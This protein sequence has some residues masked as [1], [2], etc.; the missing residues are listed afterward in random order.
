MRTHIS[1]KPNPHLLLI[2]RKG[3][4]P[5]EITISTQIRTIWTIYVE[6][7]DD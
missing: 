1:N 4:I 6:N 2:I 3:N 5:F 7:L